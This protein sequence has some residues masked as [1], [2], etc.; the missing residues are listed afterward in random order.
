M[1][2]TNLKK[3]KTFLIIGGEFS[4]EYYD[5]FLVQLNEKYGDI[6]KWSLF[7]HKEVFLFF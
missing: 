4:I 5:K 2:L 3:L 1:S 7:D 6:V